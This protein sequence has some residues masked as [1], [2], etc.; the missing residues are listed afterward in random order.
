VLPST[1]AA[2]GTPPVGEKAEVRN[3]DEAF[4]E[5]VQEEVTQELIQR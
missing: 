5:Q 3:A 4:G 2:A 1:V